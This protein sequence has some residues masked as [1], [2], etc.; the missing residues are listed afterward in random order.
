VYQRIRSTKKQPIQWETPSSEQKGVEGAQFSSLVPPFSEY[1]LGGIPLHSPVPPAVTMDTSQGLIQ[2]Q[3]SSV[4]EPLSQEAPDSAQQKPPATS[5]AQSTSGAQGCSPEQMD[6]LKAALSEAINWTNEAI[7]DL[8]K[9][10][11]PSYTEDALKTYLSTNTDDIAN[12][13]LPRLKMILAQLKRG[14]SAFQCRTAEE[15]VH[16]K[17]TAYAQPDGSIVLYPGSFALGPLMPWLLIHECGHETGLP[18]DAYSAALLSNNSKDLN[19]PFAGLSIEARLS[20]TDAYAW[21]VLADHTALL[22][23]D[24][25]P[26]PPR[27]GLGLGAAG[28]V[29]I[30]SGGGPRFVVSVEL[31]KPFGQQIFHF[32]NLHA[33]TRVDVDSTGT[34]LGTLSLGSRAFAPASLTKYRLFLDLKAGLAYGYDPGI[35]SDI[36]GPSGQAGIGVLLPTFEAGIS[37]RAFLDL[38]K[39]NRDLHEITIDGTIRF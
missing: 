5:Q 32:A 38:F 20:T 24:T 34:V 1:H 16:N 2:R 27:E 28:G 7:T 31:D 8:Q 21:F 3:L 37:Y 6:Q 14:P 18:G 23:A 12:Q 9:T 35:K 19:R 36:L 26:V 15:D 17:H 33:N 4:G 29:T 11:R 22:P 30:P 39:E 13:I 25:G 10:P